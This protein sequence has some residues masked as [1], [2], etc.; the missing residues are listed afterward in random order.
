MTREWVKRTIHQLGFDVT[1][2]RPRVDDFI[3]RHGVTTVLDV[4]ANEGQYARML[5]EWGYRGKIV[6]F[7]PVMAALQRLDLERQGDPQ[8][9]SVN[10][11]LGNSDG[12]TTINVTTSSVFSSILTPLPHLQKEFSTAAIVGTQKISVRRLDSVF[13]QYCS[14][15]DVAFLKIDTQGYERE[16]LQGALQSLPR[17]IAVQMEVSLVPYYAGE[18]TLSEH[19]GFMEEHGFDPA[20][21]EPVTYNNQIPAVDQVDAVFVQRDLV[22]F[23]RVTPASA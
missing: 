6:S 15:D 12:E 7:E 5:R 11:A 1:H 8:W 23:S 21:L 9:T 10:M 16:V 13:E 20:L 18:A 4:G 17:I 22:R 3:S 19:L 2:R 14:K